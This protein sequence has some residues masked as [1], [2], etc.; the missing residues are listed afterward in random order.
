LTRVLPFDPCSAPSYCPPRDGDV[1]RVSTSGLGLYLIRHAADHVEWI[2]HGRGGKEM[3]LTKNLPQADITEHL[4]KE[5]IMVSHHSSLGFGEIKILRVGQESRTELKRG[6]L[7]LLEIAGAERQS[8]WTSH[9][10]R[11]EPRTY[12]QRPR[13]KVSYSAAW[14]PA[15]PL[16]GMSLPSSI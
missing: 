7:D 8:I 12:A 15:S 9:L 2:N 10:P 16:T 5:A 14:A 6:L 3:R 11:P 4:A 1:N 13:P